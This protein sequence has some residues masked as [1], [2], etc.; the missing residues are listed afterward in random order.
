MAMPQP[1]MANPTI[2]ISARRPPFGWAIWIAVSVVGAAVGAIVAWQIR[3][4]WPL[5]S[6]SLMQDVAYIATLVSALIAAGAQWFFFRTF[7]SDADWW[8]PATAG[9]NLINAAIVVPAMLSLFFRPAL[10]SAPSRSTALIAGA[11]ALAAA[12]LVVGGAQALVLRGSLPRLA[13]LWIP[14]TV[15]GGLLTGII[16]TSL[17]AA[18][19]GLPAIATVSLAAV[20]GSLITAA[21]QAPL[22]FRF[23]R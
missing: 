16:T 4:L 2:T 19:F 9:A 3:S 13:P 14:A 21:C 22:L 12:G 18:F 11:L 17:S 23:L 10:S 5:G 6:A 8:A 1:A 20:T 15:L 7:K